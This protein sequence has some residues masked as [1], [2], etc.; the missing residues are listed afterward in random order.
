MGLADGEV[1]DEFRQLELE[2]RRSEVTAALLVGEVE[3]RALNELDGMRS[4]QAWCRG[5]GRWS[6]R[7]GRNMHRLARLLRTHADV[8]SPETAIFLPIAHL[9]ELARAAANPR[10]GDEIRDAMD[11]L[12]YW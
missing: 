6:H 5:I 12:L 8:L 2:R 1:V 9:H 10:C 7:D 11:A 4:V 3:R